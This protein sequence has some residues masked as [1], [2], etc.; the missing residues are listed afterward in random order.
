MVVDQ[1]LNYH[2][3]L[4]LENIPSY[5]A[6]DGDNGDGSLH[7]SN[8]KSSDNQYYIEICCHAGYT[9]AEEFPSL[10]RVD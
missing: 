5:G 3:L 10:I 6:C 9:N 1:I 7:S 8:C 2:C 4:N